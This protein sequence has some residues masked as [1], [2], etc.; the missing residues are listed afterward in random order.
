MEKVYIIIL[1][2]IDV[3]QYLMP[4]ELDFENLRYCIDNYS[5]TFMYIRDCGGVRADGKYSCQG[6][7][8]VREEL[9]DKTLDFRKDTSG[10][11]IIVDSDDLFCFPLEDYPKGFSVAYERIEPIGIGRMI[12]LS[13]GIDPYD[14]KLPE[15][16]TSTLRTVIDDHFMEIRFEGRIHLKFHSWLEKPHWKYWTIDESKNNKNSKSPRI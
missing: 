8:K 5:P 12:M 16:T 6:M 4:I 1:F 14:P 2:F 15:P 9:T 13:R 3:E 11:H 7:S 10:L